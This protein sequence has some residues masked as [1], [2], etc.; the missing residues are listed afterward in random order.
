M[1]TL[2]TRQRDILRLILEGSR[3]LSSSELAGLLNI[4]P[5][6]VNYSIQG[7]KIWLSQHHQDLKTV[8]GAGF[9]VEIQPEQ[10][11]KLSQE[12]NASSS[13]QIVLSISQRQQLLALFLLSQVEPFIVSQLEQKANVSRMT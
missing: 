9:A 13:V 12:I 3:P 10:A 2:T 4:T 8:P 6:Q 1:I 7:V 11:R 5:R